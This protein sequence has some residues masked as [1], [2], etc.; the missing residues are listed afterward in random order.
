MGTLHG[1]SDEGVPLVVDNLQ[2]HTAKTNHARDIHILSSAFLLIF[3][4]YGAAQNLETTVNT[5]ENMG[6]IALGIL[7]LSFTFFSL[8]AS[9]VIRFLGSK[10]ALVLGTSGYWLFIAANLMP[11]W[12]TMIPTSLYLGFAASVIWVGQGTYLTSTARSHARDLQLHEGTVIGSFNGEFWA[13]YACHQVVGNLMSLVILKDGQEGS[14]SGTTL[15][16]ILFLC[17]MTLGTILMCF[18]SKRNDKGEQESADSSVSLCSSVTSL[19]KLVITPLLD[20]RMLLI[21]PLFAYSGLQQALVWAKF[22][23]DI[24]KPALGTSGIG[25]AMAVYGALDAIVSIRTQEFAVSSYYL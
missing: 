10:N 14:T 1:A 25:G 16:F 7:Y 15:L 9:L 18:L 2:I 24:V 3:L 20:M 8:V 17:C 21:V 6:T 23:K 5:E 13:A 22:T 12:Y 4:A 19:L 11:T